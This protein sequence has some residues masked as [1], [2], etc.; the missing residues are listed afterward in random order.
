MENKCVILL[1]SGGIDST[2]LLAKLS[3]DGFNVIAVSF[4]Y[5]QKHRI[6][7]RYA[8]ENARKYN[9][10]THEIIKLD[11]NIFASSALVNNGID[12]AGYKKGELP[13]G[14]VNTYVPYRN[15]IFISNALSI[16]ETRGIKDIY[17]AFNSDDQ[18]NYWDCS[19]EFLQTINAISGPMNKIQVKAPFIQKSKS[20]VIQLAKELQVNLNE[21]ITCYQPQ[22]SQECGQCLSCL[23]KQ[24]ALEND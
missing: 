8:K 17:L 16:A 18:N 15:L 10:K 21:T 4:D 1:L 3:S 20:E 14:I 2:T 11:K 19:M 13:L 6:E 7:L 5:E 23:S 9:V 22:E 24:Q 12:V